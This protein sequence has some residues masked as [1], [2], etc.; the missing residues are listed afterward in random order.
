M[1]SAVYPNASSNETRQLNRA[2]DGCLGR[3]LSKSEWKNEL[4]NVGV[5]WDKKKSL[6]DAI[7]LK[8]YTFFRTEIEQLCK[9]NPNTVVLRRLK[10]KKKWLK[11]SLNEEEKRFIQNE[12]EKRYRQ[13]R[14]FTQDARYV[15]H[16]WMLSG[17]INVPY[18]S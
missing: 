5:H 16:L 8:E 1:T 10:G 15:Y 12:N 18:G 13:Q 9:S 14:L 11:R 3:G 2:I 6:V 7:V 4:E 17:R